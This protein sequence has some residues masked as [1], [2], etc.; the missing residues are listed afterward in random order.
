[1]PRWW[2]RSGAL[3]SLLAVLLLALRAVMPL[4]LRATPRLARRLACPAWLW[5]L[6]ARHRA[7][8][9]LLHPPPVLPLLHSLYLPHV[10]HVPR[11]L[12]LQLQS[13]Y[14]LRQGSLSC[15]GLLSL[16]SHPPFPSPRSA[17]RA[18]SAG[19]CGDVPRAHARPRPRAPCVTFAWSVCPS[20]RPS[21]RH[22]LTCFAP[23]AGRPT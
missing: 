10:P 17:L 7:L 1:M 20:T 16:T 2:C 12:H 21:Q 4:T 6:A 15:G 3:I 19:A 22:A 8:P 23:R 5:E 18:V 9:R 11:L 14:W 13:K